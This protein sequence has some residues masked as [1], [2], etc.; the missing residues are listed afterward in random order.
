M[1]VYLF[2]P[3]R[4]SLPGTYLFHLDNQYFLDKYHKSLL[5]SFLLDHIQSH[6]NINILYLLSMILQFSLCTINEENIAVMHRTP[7]LLLQD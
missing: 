7:L 4:Y 6:P 5:F 2:G 1:C 3:Y